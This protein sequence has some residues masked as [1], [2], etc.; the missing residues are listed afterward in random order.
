[1]VICGN[2]IFANEQPTSSY[3][4]VIAIH[5]D[6]EVLMGFVSGWCDMDAFDDT[7]TLGRR[8]K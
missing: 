2:T 7:A 8:E 6:T 4:L 5:P 1:M 3:K